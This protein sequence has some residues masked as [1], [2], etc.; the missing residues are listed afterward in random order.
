[1]KSD[2]K[3]LEIAQGKFEN[4]INIMEFAPREETKLELDKKK[5]SVRRKMTAKEDQFDDELY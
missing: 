1:M 2:M 4:A 3:N 5:K